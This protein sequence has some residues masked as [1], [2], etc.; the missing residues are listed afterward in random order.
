M[1]SQYELRNSMG[2]EHIT[3]LIDAHVRPGIVLALY[4][5]D[6]MKYSNPTNSTKTLQSSFTDE[7][8]VQWHLAT[9]PTSH[10]SKVPRGGRLSQSVDQNHLT[11]NEALQIKMTGRLWFFNYQIRQNIHLIAF[12]C[13]CGVSKWAFSCIEGMLFLGSHLPTSTD[14]RWQ[15]QFILQIYS[16]RYIKLYT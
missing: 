7:K 4:M 12:Q 15:I 3:I 2:H 10:S 5:L 13:W 16:H 1:G 6:T 14:T 9:C 11:P 8:L